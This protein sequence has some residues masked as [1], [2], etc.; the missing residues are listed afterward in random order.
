MPR[1]NKIAQIQAK[2]A[3]STTLQKL[4]QKKNAQIRTKKKKHITLPWKNYAMKKCTNLSQKSTYHYIKK[5][6]VRK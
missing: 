3:P 1:K 4:C 5:P 6:M 2:T